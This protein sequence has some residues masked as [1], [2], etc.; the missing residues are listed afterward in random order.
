MLVQGVQNIS[1]IRDEFKA[2]VSE[3]QTFYSQFEEGGGG[4][5]KA[6]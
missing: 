4:R 2:K 3:G 1:E 6:Y 5:R